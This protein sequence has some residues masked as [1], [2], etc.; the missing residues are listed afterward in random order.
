MSS[1]KSKGTSEGY[2][3]PLQ[4]INDPKENM[5]ILVADIQAQIES[6]LSKT[7]SLKRTSDLLDMQIEKLE[8]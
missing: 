6:L 1:I 3:T 8:G 7:E 4:P 2:G 5:R